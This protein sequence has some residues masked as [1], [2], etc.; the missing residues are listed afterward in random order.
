MTVENG[1]PG[2]HDKNYT[3]MTSA[4]KGLGDLEIFKEFADSIFDCLRD[5]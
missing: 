4:R 1:S 5:F 3:F 2:F